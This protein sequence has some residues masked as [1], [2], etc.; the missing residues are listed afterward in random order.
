MS[1]DFSKFLISLDGDEWV[2]VSAGAINNADKTIYLHLR[3]TT[4]FRHQRNGKCPVQMAD[5]L[6]LS[7]FDV[8]AA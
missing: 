8:E 3:S 5:W 6:P 4:R 7:L 2:V 1:T